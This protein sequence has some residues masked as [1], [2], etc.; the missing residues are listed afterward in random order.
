MLTVTNTISTKSIILPSFF[1][2]VSISCVGA[3]SKEYKGSSTQR[4]RERE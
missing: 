1:G 4:E 2:F 3:C